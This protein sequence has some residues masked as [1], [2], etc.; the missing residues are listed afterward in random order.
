M[1]DE[2]DISTI[3][4][5]KRHRKDMGDIDALARSIAENGLLQSIVLRSDMQLVCGERRIRAFERLGRARI[6]ARI[7]DL[8]EIVFGEQ[9]ENIDRKDFTIEER[10]AI[11]AEIE[12]KLVGRQGERSDLGKGKL[13]Q[14]FGQVKGLKTEDIAAQKAGFK[15]GESYRQAK[16]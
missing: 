9:A 2:I 6:P 15:N 8:N 4:V 7:V 14:N 1:T 13:V 3:R 12:A 10:V 16:A 11:G 5:G